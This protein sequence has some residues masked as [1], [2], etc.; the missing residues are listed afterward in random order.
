MRI[1]KATRRSLALE[2]IGRRRLAAARSG[3]LMHAIDKA[4]A[5]AETGEAVDVAQQETPEEATNQNHRSG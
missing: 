3:E 4:L 1:R 2:I 5:A